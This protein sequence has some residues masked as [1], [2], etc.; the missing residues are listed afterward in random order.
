MREHL[1]DYSADRS[2]ADLTY[3]TTINL[4]LG[5]MSKKPDDFSLRK[6]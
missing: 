6:S 1:K 5:M 2:V 3:F 4:L